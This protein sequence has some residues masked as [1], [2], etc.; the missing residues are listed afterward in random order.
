MFLG[1]RLLVLPCLPE[2]YLSQ[3]THTHTRTLRTPR[4]PSPP[5]QIHPRQLNANPVGSGRVSRRAAWPR[6]WRPPGRS[7]GHVAAA[8]A[9]CRARLADFGSERRPGEPA[10]GRRSG[11]A[12]RRGGRWKRER[13]ASARGERR[14]SFFPVRPRGE[15]GVETATYAPWRRHGQRKR[16]ESCTDQGRAFSHVA[17]GAGQCQEVN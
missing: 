4:F 7:P 8:A 15:R 14:Y 11:G 10:D 9:A 6:A 5:R 2:S 3:P 1:I 12:R 17:R 16:V 13:L